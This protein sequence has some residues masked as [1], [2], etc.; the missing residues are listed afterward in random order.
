MLTR[1]SDFPLETP[2]GDESK[3]L[4]EKGYDL[5]TKNYKPRAMILDHGK[6]ARLWDKDGNEYIDFGS[7]IAVNSL[8]HQDPDLLKA[9]DE[10]SRKLWHT[11]NVFFTEPSIR[12]ADE[13]LE[14]TPWG[15][16]VYFGNSGAEANEAAI[17][18]IR[19]WAADQGRPPEAREII[20]FTGSFH[21][22]TVAA[23]TATAQPKYHAGFEPLPGGFVYC[24]SFNDLDALKALVTEKTAAIM[25]EP[26]QGEGGIVPATT[27][28]MQ[29]VEKIC[30][31]KNILLV[32]DEIQCGMGRTG[33]LWGHMYDG[34]VTPDIMT[35][36]KALGGGLP[37]GAVVLGEKVEETFQLGS[38]GSTFGGN[39]VMCAVARASLA[40]IASP[41]MM[42]HVE[43]QSEQLFAGLGAIGNETGLFAEVRGRGLM[44]GCE[45]ISEWHGKAGELTETC[46]SFGVLTLVAGPNVL[47][48]LPPLTATDEEIE[49]GLKRLRTALV[50]AKQTFA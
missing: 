47:R 20:T 41:Q 31:E 38:H 30:R 26:L 50:H 3:S 27:E 24:D 39:P 42:A 25:F 2:S 32:V 7:G 11:S 15:K 13:L 33:V 9:L 14:V 8:G 1:N 6:G 5:L 45:L 10:Q 16:R 35:I 28:F 40:K 44:I 46:R 49:V 29:G 4:I 22:R 23:V 19:K 43:Q 34:G 48:L 37:I 12:L 18:L 21:G 36:A 17:K